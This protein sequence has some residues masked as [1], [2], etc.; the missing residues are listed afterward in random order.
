MANEIKKNMPERTD[1]FYM[2]Q[3]LQ[4]AFNA[5]IGI[6][7]MAGFVLV[8]IFM[9]FNSLSRPPQIV[10]IDGTTGRTY[11]PI[12]QGT[13]VAQVLID[14][15]LIYYTT[16]V[17]ENFFNFDY[18]YIE[19]AR[20]SVY[21][22]G[23]ATFRNSLGGD[24]LDGAEVKKC[25]TDQLESFIKWEMYPKITKRNDPFYTV[26]ATI[27]R[28]VKAGGLTKETKTFNVRVEWGRLNN[29]VD[30]TKRPHSLVLLDIKIL[31]EGS[32]ELNE[33]INSVK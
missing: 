29:N 4:M 20:K 32:V 10:V 27:H 5:R 24:F 1:R 11:A 22:L 33:Q 15:Q 17:C 28:V 7:V 2:K 14:R 21:E 26:F 25:I 23:N 16:Q 8:L 13:N 3:I 31:N 19:I 12:A 18:Q 30:Y 9:L 6:I